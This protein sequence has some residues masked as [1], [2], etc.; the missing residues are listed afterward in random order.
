MY[1]ESTIPWPVKQA[2]GVFPSS[3]LSEKQWAWNF[4]A[5]PREKEGGGSVD[6]VFFTWTIGGGTSGEPVKT[7]CTNEPV[8]AIFPFRNTP[9]G[10]PV[11]VGKKETSQTAIVILFESG[12][13]IRA[14]WWALW[15]KCENDEGEPVFRPSPATL[16][17][18]KI[19]AASTKQACTAA[20]REI[21]KLADR[22]FGELSMSVFIGFILSLI[23]GVFSSVELFFV[24]VLFL[25]A[26][27][28]F[29]TQ[30]CDDRFSF[31]R[32]SLSHVSIT[33]LRGIGM[34]STSIWGH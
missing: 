25:F 4:V 3:P 8:R 30:C 21:S 29:F 6:D 15:E 1:P 34:R 22:T 14:N 17:S 33:Q 13:L 32:F 27:F 28:F 19:L 10:R 20:S 2:P 26:L 5:R 16:V 12:Y 23:Y 7:V 9:D 31:Y 24:V 18:K 11:L